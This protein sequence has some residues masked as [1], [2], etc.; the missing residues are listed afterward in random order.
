[1]GDVRKKIKQSFKKMKKFS[2]TLKW[3]WILS[4]FLSPFI[5]IISIVVL[6]NIEI[7]H[8]IDWNTFFR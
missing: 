1:M 8:S 3:I 7:Y 5:G 6:L 2:R 4:L